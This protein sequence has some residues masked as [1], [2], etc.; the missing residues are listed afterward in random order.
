MQWTPRRALIALVIV[1][2]IWA[3]SYT[4]A[5][6]TL[7]VLSPVELNGLRFT[8][9]GLVLLPFL[10]RG[11][12][13]P[14]LSRADLPRLAVLCLCGFVFNKAA[15]FTGLN[16]TTASDTALLIASESMWTALLGWLVLH[17][18]LER[19]SVGGLIVGAIGVYIVLERGLNAPSLGSG[20]HLLG[21]GL[22]V[23]ALV[24]EAF[25]TV[26]GKSSLDR[27]P[28]LLIT[29]SSILGSLVVWIPATAINVAV[30]GLPHMT[31][32]AWL[33]VLYMAIPSTVVGYLVWM[34]VLRYVTA[35]DAAVTLYLQPLAGTA[36]AVVIL[37][38]R[39]TWG[40][41]AGGLCIIGGVW[42]AGRH[43][44]PAV[45]AAVGAEPLAS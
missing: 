23:V 21:D 18:A 40:T 36:L 34:V 24:F 37:S 29:A 13:G 41:L 12:S 27:Y 33:G 17:E 25:Y 8:I 38:E 4:A 30:A 44:G 5:K 19:A 1:N 32:T 9:A 15:E 3:G 6:E 43:P 11:W 28:G 10:L 31:T 39:P 2:L 14:R 22:I 16:L 26:L 7:R 45:A 20:R 35:A 42:L